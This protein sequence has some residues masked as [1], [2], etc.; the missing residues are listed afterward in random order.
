MPTEEKERLDTET[1]SKSHSLKY[2]LGEADI[3]D[4]A[5][6]MHQVT[7]PIKSILKGTRPAYLEWQNINY[8]VP[9]KAKK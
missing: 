3:C 7:W 2:L 1:P 6:G 4:Q 8:F 5:K 9:E